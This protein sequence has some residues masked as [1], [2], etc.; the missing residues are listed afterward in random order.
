MFNAKGSCNTHFM[1]MKIKNFEKRNTA[2]RK[3][4]VICVIVLCLT[5]SSILKYN[6]ILL[7]IQ[8]M[9]QKSR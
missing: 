5:K 6:K 1:A 2:K 3:T 4:F 8:V 7:K 9:K